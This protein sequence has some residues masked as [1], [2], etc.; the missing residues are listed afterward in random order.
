MNKREQQRLEREKLSEML[1]N[2]K[3]KSFV[4]NC[5]THNEDDNSLDGIKSLIYE[6]LEK[7]QAQG[8]RIG[9]TTLLNIIKEEVDNCS[10]LDE[11]K[12]K[13]H[14]HEPH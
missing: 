11:L 2:P 5:L 14:Q 3:L 12:T 8:V 7:A 10:T 6:Q 13:L 4:D 1:N 9:W